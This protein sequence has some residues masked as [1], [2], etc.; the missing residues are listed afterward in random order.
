MATIAE[1]D[2]VAGAAAA[3]GGLPDW[4]LE[5]RTGVDE[6]KEVI[7]RAARWEGKTKLL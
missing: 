3:A 2:M 1:T 6:A 5:G 4:E 7:R